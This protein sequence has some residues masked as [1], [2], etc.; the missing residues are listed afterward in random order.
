M[1]R[2]LVSSGSVPQAILKKQI[3]RAT[4]GKE[5]ITWV[6]GKKVKTWTCTIN[7]SAKKVYMLTQNQ[8]LLADSTA[9]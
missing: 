2:D 4:I 1:Q 8:S 6:N 5:T 7:K 3:Y 9:G